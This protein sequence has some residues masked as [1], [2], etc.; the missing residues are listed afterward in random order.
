[1]IIKSLLFII[2]CIFVMETFH[3]LYR[4]SEE[5]FNNSTLPTLPTQST[6][7]PTAEQ[8]DIDNTI[9]ANCTKWRLNADKIKLMTYKPE[10]SEELDTPYFAS[11]APMEYRKE[12][13]YYSNP[14]YLIE[15]GIRRNNDETSIIADIQAKYTLETDQ[16]KKEELA[17][18][19]SIYNWKNYIFKDKDLKGEQRGMPDII[20]DY[21]PGEIGMSRPW[22]ERH[23]HLPDYKRIEIGDT[24]YINDVKKYEKI[25][26]YSLWMAV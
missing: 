22:R 25:N 8:L 15:E 9:N 24:K 11:F 16:Q 18:E 17:N 21:Y 23:S 13:V 4:Q 7:P 1:M 12:R 19:L 10:S 5:Y 20:T 2:V 3:N 6:L 26:P 14:H